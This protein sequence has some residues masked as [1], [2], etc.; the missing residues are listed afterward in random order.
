MLNDVKG[1]I[2]GG[3]ESTHE[4]VKAKLIVISEV[5]SVRLGRSLMREMVLETFYHAFGLHLKQV[6]LWCYPLRGDPLPVHCPCE[7]DRRHP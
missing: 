1:A 6:R 2:G 5:S 4:F 3:Q 7:E